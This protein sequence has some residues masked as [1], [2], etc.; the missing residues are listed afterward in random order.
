MVIVLKNKEFAILS[1]TV[2]MAQMKLRRYVPV[3]LEVVVLQS[4]GVAGSTTG[5]MILTGGVATKLLHQAQVLTNINNSG[6][7]LSLEFVNKYS[8]LRTR[9]PDLQ[10]V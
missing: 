6:L 9:I 8:D 10:K 7:V 4:T 5:R 2:R 1:M 3:D